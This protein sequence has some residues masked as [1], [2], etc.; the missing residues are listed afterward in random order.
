MLQCN[1]RFTVHRANVLGKARIGAEL[2]PVELGLRKAYA[3]AQQEGLAAQEYEPE[4]KAAAEIN[5]LYSYIHTVLHGVKA[6]ASRK[7]KQQSA[8][9]R[10]QG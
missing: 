1:I 3:R 10:L 2:V 7:E 4:G 9:K 6:D 8:R 5:D